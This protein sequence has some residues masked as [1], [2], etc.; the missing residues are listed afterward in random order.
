MIQNEKVVENLRGIDRCLIG[1]ISDTHGM[2]R[3]SVGRAFENVD[4]IIHAGDIDNLETLEAIEKIA[5]VIPVR[6]NMDRGA[7]AGRLPSDETIQ[8]G[9]AVIH[10]LHDS[11]HLDLDPWAAGISA[12]ISGHT[13][14][15][16]VSKKNGVLFANPGSAGPVRSNCPVSAA[17]LYIDDATLDFRVINL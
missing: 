16:S 2:L 1:V 15:P 14:K 6:G 5:P 13:H 4:A 8:A 17:L 7:W 9:K 11:Y 12:V 3:P 10:I